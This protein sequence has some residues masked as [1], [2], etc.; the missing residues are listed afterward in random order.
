MSARRILAVI[1][2][3]ILAAPPV[4]AGVPRW[5]KWAVVGAVAGGT[6]VI[7]AGRAGH[8]NR[9]ADQLRA[10]VSTGEFSGLGA[11]PRGRTM[12]APD[13]AYLLPE[14]VRVLAEADRLNG[15]G[16]RYRRASIGLAVI[17]I[18][19]MGFSVTTMA[20]GFAVRKVVR[21]GGAQ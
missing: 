3:V 6:A 1:I 10:S 16:D 5:L 7:L 17:S 11:A 15:R 18:G 9:E 19:A 13:T 14:R 12:A 4:S 20:R 21:F 8:A 2:A